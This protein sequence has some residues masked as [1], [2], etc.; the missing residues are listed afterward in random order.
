MGSFRRF[1]PPNGEPQKG[2]AVGKSELFADVGAMRLDSSG[3]NAELFCDFALASSVADEA[4][5]LQFPV[6]ESVQWK[7]RRGSG[8]HAAEEHL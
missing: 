7:D 1:G 3:L 8:D 5:D 2:V 6:G 4:E